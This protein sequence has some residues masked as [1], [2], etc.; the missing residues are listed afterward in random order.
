MVRLSIIIPA[1][2]VADYILNCLDS[3][4]NQGDII[5]QC[6]IIVINDGSTDNTLE[7]VKNYS[8]QRDCIQIHTQ[9]N[10]GVGAARNKGLDMAQGEY[11]Y[12]LDPDDY[13]AKGVLSIIINKAE[14]KSLDLLAFNTKMT[15]TYSDMESMG[16][17]D[18][19]VLSKVLSGVE[20][21]GQFNYRNEIWWYILRKDFLVTNEI[22]FIEGRWMEDAIFTASVLLRVKKLMHLELDAHRYVKVPNSAMNNT[23]DSHNIKIIYANAE[24]AVAYYDLIGSLEENEEKNLA[25]I[26]RMRERQESFI[27]FSI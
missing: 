1:Y 19:V 12:F 5:K 9:P 17:L 16:D 2:N 20:Y 8:K 21:M 18:Q 22:R 24:A 14:K 7:V 27:F 10:A 25:C 15:E 13:L 23:E 26:Q 4:F 3:L 6:E 11:I